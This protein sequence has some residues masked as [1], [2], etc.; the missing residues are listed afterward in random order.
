[1]AITNPDYSVGTVSIATGTKA[2]TGVGTMWLSADLEKGDQFGFDGY[3]AARIDTID[4]DGTITLLDT[5]RGPTLANSPYFL[6]YQGVSSLTGTAVVVRRMLSQPLI[7]AFTGLAAVANKL[8]YFTGANTMATTDFTV[9]GR[10]LVGAANAAAARGVLAAAAAAGQDFTGYVASQNPAFSVAPVANQLVANGEIIIQW[11]G[12]S[13]D[14]GS[15][16]GQNVF[17]AAKTGP[18]LFMVNV[19]YGDGVNQ[20]TYGV[21][22]KTNGVLVGRVITLK[23]GF[24]IHLALT[25]V[26]Y[27]NAGDVVSAWTFLDSGAGNPYLTAAP[28]TR[29]SGV[30]LV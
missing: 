2:L 29:F 20:G 5:W 17:T 6:R 10:S 19:T 14:R 11:P 3:P 9:T 26:V 23:T 25:Q 1:M 21:Q 4:D 18:H 12:I 24:W 16:F 8:M 7:T 30:Q 22:L 13:F 28:N 27:L 15:R